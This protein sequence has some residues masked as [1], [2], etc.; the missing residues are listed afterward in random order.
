[1]D[2]KNN[3]DNK[4]IHTGEPDHSARPHAAG[5]EQPRDRRSGARR[6]LLW[7]EHNVR[8]AHTHDLAQ[9]QERARRSWAFPIA[10]PTERRYALPALIPYL[11]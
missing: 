2:L 10:L 7:Q 6:A 1:M 8:E 4:R 5:V 9:E 11:L 3:T